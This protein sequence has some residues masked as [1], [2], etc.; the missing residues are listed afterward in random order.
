MIS[1]EVSLTVTADYSEL[2]TMLEEEPEEE[3]EL[4]SLSFLTKFWWMIS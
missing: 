3:L 4:S 2:E 1:T